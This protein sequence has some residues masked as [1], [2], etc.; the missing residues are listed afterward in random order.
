MSKLSIVVPCYNEEEAIPL[1]YPAVEKVVKQMPVETEYWFVNDGSSDG[2]LA[3]LRKL[4]KQD[5][6][7][8]H[9]VS[10]SRNFG[11]EAGLYAG[12]QAATGD[13]IVVMDADLQDPPEYLPEMYKDISTGEYDCVGMRRTDRKGEAKFKSFLSDQFYNVINKI[14]DTKIV[15]GARDYRMMTRQMV[16]AVLSL[17][18]YNRF[19]KGIFNWVGFKTKY[20]PYK[21]VER[22]AGTT[23][24]STWKLFKYAIDGITDFSEAPLAIATWAGGLTAFISIIGMIIVVIRK[25][26]EPSSS[27]FGWAS[28]VCIILFLGGIQLLCL[29]IVGRY[30]GRIYMQTKK[31]PIYIIKE[32]K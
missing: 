4:H 30:I 17:T 24:W 23:D 31:R 28:M 9:Y 32:K 11:K 25:I 12:L 13:Y 29:G 16:D 19:S 26:L 20:L 7:R 1:F 3:E 8:V 27:A 10:F 22:V 5:P 2:T 14:S 15:S 18:E 21:N 6:E